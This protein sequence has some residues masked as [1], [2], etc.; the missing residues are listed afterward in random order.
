[1]AKIDRLKEEIG[2]LKVVFAVLVAIDASLIGWLAQNYAEASGIL[3]VAATAATVA[4]TIGRCTRQPVG[5]PSSQA[6][7][8]SVMVWVVI[9]ALTVMVVGLMLVVREAEHHGA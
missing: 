1:M 2:W 5:V 8:G 4:I 3:V 7:G 6:A 9:A